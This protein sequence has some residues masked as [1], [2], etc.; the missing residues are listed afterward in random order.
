MPRHEHIFTQKDIECRRPLHPSDRM[1]SAD[2]LAW[3]IACGEEEERKDQLVDEKLVQAISSWC[4]REEKT[5]D[6][7]T[8]QTNSQ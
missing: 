5:N 8:T 3:L 7:E 4:E 6:S 2:T 1:A